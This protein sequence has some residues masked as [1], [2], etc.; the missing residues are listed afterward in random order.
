MVAL[1][2]VEG[3]VDSLEEAVSPLD[4]DRLLLVELRKDFPDD[5]E[6]ATEYWESVKKLS[7]QS[8]PSLGPKVDRVLRLLPTYFDYIEAAREATSCEDVFSSYFSTGVI[9]FFN[10]ERDYRRDVFLVLINRID[11]L[12]SLAD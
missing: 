1:T 10:V 8:D 12:V 5:R 9:D 3:Q 11:A 7:V 6:A 4:T 2:A